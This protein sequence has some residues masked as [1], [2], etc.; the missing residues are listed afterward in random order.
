[1]ALWYWELDFT[2]AGLPLFLPPG[3]LWTSTFQ[4]LVA[5]LLQLALPLARPLHFLALGP[6]LALLGQAMV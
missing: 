4:P 1:M 3:A 6:C 2:L 5:A